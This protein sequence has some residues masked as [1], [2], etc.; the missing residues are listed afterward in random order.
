MALFDQLKLNALIQNFGSP[1]QWMRSLSLKENRS[2][3]F[4]IKRKGA[5]PIAF[6]STSTEP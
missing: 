5:D 4:T 6:P 3:N 1:T 2:H